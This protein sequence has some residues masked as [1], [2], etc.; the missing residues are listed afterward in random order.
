MPT[1]GEQGNPLHTQ[2][3]GT[4]RVGG[5]CWWQQG[6]PY[7]P[8]TTNRFGGSAHAEYGPLRVISYPTAPFGKVT[9]RYNDFRSAYMQNPCPAG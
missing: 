3:V 8:G 1:H 4:T 5:S 2:G 6:G 7:I 9:T